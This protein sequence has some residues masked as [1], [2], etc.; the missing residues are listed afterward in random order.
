MYEYYYDLLVNCLLSLDFANIDY[1]Y[2]EWHAH[3][4]IEIT[5]RLISKVV[6][7]INNN[8][9]N[10]RTQEFHY[11]KFKSARTRDLMILV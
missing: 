7:V 6:S 11:F 3:A 4:A 8:Q 10:L 5:L 1:S 2:S 9:M